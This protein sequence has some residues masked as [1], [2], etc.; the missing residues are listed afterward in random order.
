MVH[1]GIFC[2]RHCTCFAMVPSKSQL[3]Q[4]ERK[5]KSLKKELNKK[6]STELKRD[7]KTKPNI[8]VELLPSIKEKSKIGLMIEIRLRENENYD[9]L[10]KI[11]PLFQKIISLP[12]MFFKNIE[13]TSCTD[14]SFDAKKFK[15][16]GAFE[17][18]AKIYLSPELISKIGE[19][20]ISGL[21]LVFNK[22]PLG[23]R[24]VGAKLENGKISVSVSTSYKFVAT[25]DSLPKTYHHNLQV[26]ELFVEAT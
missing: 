25:K 9:N 24:S 21:Q 7:L 11:F 20:R 17:L 8:R 3:N 15:T 22:S 18:P 14:F 5:L 23:I 13:G 16:T 2:K 6:I 1:E 10:Y 4:L 19:T 12:Q 26:A